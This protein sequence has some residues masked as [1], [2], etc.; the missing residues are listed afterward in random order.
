M[1]FRSITYTN[2][3]SDSNIFQHQSSNGAIHI[4][5]DGPNCENGA[6]ALP[7]RQL[8]SMPGYEL[9][10]LIGLSIL[11]DVKVEN[12]EA[13]NPKD[14]VSNGSK[15]SNRQDDLDNGIPT[16][17]D[18]GWISDHGEVDP[19]ERLSKAESA[20]FDSSKKDLMSDL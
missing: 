7:L 9:P 15:G 4:N 5:N 18:L 8:I 17:P 14:K 6:A 10:N 20:V 3:E 2:E 1:P 13:V 16:L 11:D 12:T 19:L